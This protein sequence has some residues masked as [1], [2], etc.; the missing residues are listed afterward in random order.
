[1]KFQ[2]ADIPDELASRIFLCS[3]LVFAVAMIQFLRSDL[4]FDEIVTVFDFAMLRDHRAIFT[5]YPVANN[6]MLFS[7]IEWW[8]LYAV[9]LANAM[10][11]LQG[12]SLGQSEEVL[13]LPSAA[14]A[15]A[16]GMFLY[17]RGRQSLG[18]ATALI[19][20]L[21]MFASP[22]FLSFS[23]QL[24]GYGLSML[25]SAMAT[26]GVVEILAGKRRQ[27]AFIYGPAAAFLPVAIP[28]NILVTFSLWLFVA[29]VLLRRR[30][31]LRNLVFVGAMGLV[32]ACGMTVYL[33]IFDKFMKVVK[34]TG[35]WSDGGTVAAHLGL[36]LLVHL[37]AF[38]AGCWST[39]L[40]TPQK[41]RSA[42]NDPLRRTLPL[43]AV[44]CALPIATLA[45]T[46]APFPRVFLSYL[47]PISLCALWFFRRDN[48]RRMAD[49]SVII[50][51]MVASTVV[52]YRISAFTV[53]QGLESGVVRQ[54]LLQQFYA[55]RNDISEIVDFL[56]HYEAVPER[57]RIFI[58]IHYF[59]AMRYYWLQ[60]RQEPRRLECLNGGKLA[61]LRM[62]QETYRHVPQVIVTYDP[63][64]AIK[65][66][67]ST[68]GQTPVLERIYTR[69]AIG[70]YRVI[71]IEQAEQPMRRPRTALGQPI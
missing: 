68:T 44:C 58:D 11:S 55:R 71:A 35:G 9:S 33:L 26:I 52:W 19:L 22:L 16:T 34:L 13:R 14:F 21:L 37:G 45:L 47:P 61:P 42:A 24:R 23:Y 66:Y 27:G 49:F 59:P 4:W 54:N 40:R 70:V 3:L 12:M 63:I 29:I 43:L 17:I 38:V 15:L 1:M 32:S 39:R 67:T 6:H 46:R 56:A 18:N 51:M 62:P 41:T 28:S 30:C 31:D 8:W 69:T 57:A 2:P 53:Q 20:A 50:F 5:T 36:A 65:D 48:F 10:L 60:Q 64:Q 25:L 7:F